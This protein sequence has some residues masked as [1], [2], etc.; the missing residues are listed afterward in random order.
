MKK[1]FIN[2]LDTEK[3]N[4]LIKK[5]DKL[6]KQLQEYLYE[7]QMFW[8]LDTTENCL[9]KDYHKYLEYHDHYSS[10]YFTIKDWRKFIDNVGS[11]YL[12]DKGLEIYKEIIE[13]SKKLDELEEYSD[14]YYE[15]EEKLEKKCK[16]ILDDLEELL[17]SYEE[18]PNEDDAIQ[19]ADE[20]EQL[21]GYY[22]EEYEDGFCDGVIR[23]D[24]AYTETFI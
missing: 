11:D 15:L 22:I 2:D 14:T 7:E 17:H 24:I 21:E 8:Q 23:K 3:R 9:G 6:I 18:Y 20:M 13:E 4:E 1:I 16:I 19:Y 10:F 5:N 12:T